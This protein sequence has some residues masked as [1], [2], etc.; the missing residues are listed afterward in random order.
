M[1]AGKVPRLGTEMNN[2]FCLKLTSQLTH[3]DATFTCTHPKRGLLQDVRR[4]VKGKSMGGTASGVTQATQ[5]EALLK[6]GPS[7]TF[8]YLYPG[9]VFG[10]T[11]PRR[12][13]SGIYHDLNIA[14]L[15]PKPN[16]RGMVAVLN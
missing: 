4:W 8:H 16:L 13:P 3:F 10:K 6:V 14:S 15:T 2:T 1:F 9:K 12:D 7:G 11:P 5:L